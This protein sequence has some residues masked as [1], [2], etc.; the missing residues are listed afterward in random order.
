MR[1]ILLKDNEFFKAWILS[2]TPR[3]WRNGI[4][5]T[6]REIHGILSNFIQGQLITALIVGIME[7]IGL[8]IIR[9]KYPLILGIIGGIANVIPYFG[10]IIGGIPAVAIALNSVTGKSN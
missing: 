5:K 6:G 3:R 8:S 2:L 4:I 1:I 9:I 10:P 7:M